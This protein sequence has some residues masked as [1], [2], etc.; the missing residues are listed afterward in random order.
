L[1][2]PVRRSLFTHLEQGGDHESDWKE[3]FAP[4]A[5]RKNAFLT[6]YSPFQPGPDQSY[7]DVMQTIQYLT[8]SD[9]QFRTLFRSD[10][11]LLPYL[12]F[13][14][15]SPLKLASDNQQMPSGTQR[16]QDNFPY[17]AAFED[18]IRT[19]HGRPVV[20]QM[21]DYS[22]FNALPHK[23][24][25]EMIWI[26]RLYY[27]NLLQGKAMP[28]EADAKNSGPRATWPS[29]WSH[30]NV[31]TG[32]PQ[33]REAETEQE[34]YTQFLQWASNSG[35]VER[36]TKST[37]KDS[38]GLLSSRG[39]QAF[40]EMLSPKI[41]KDVLDIM[42]HGLEMGSKDERIPTP[43]EDDKA[44]RS[45]APKREAN[46]P[47]PRNDDQNPNAVVSTSTTSEYTVNE[48]G[49]VDTSV[50]VWKRFADGRESVTTTSHTEDPR[51]IET[52]KD[53]RKSDDEN[54]KAPKQK[55]KQGWFWN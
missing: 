24:V 28:Q 19:M 35:D 30:A 39:K 3:P 17:Q 34:M 23:G 44:S 7:R 40:Q 4:D 15:Y 32:K 29:S 51:S 45:L 38:E 14:P 18:L 8:Y 36:A 33:G 20:P 10:H 50:T 55:S 21:S 41:M 26:R 9:L 53:E 52:D 43:L 37:L 5:F 22:F 27:A 31:E 54:G 1:Y 2:S 47:T 16:K 13:S 46:S 25:N 49:S 11:S 48:D 42:Q 12:L 6:E